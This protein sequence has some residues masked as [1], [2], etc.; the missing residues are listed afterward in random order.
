VPYPYSS[1]IFPRTWITPLRAVGT[2]RGRHERQRPNG[3]RALTPAP[4]KAVGVRS[5]QCPRDRLAGW[6]SNALGPARLVRP[7]QSPCGAQPA[8]V[9]RPQHPGSPGGRTAAPG[10]PPFYA[11]DRPKRRSHGLD[12]VQPG[13]RESTA[14]GA[15]LPT[16]R[17]GETAQR[18]SSRQ[19]VAAPRSARSGVTSWRRK[20]TDKERS[21]S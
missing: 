3:C 15:K 12:G 1:W 9:P 10:G 14:P 18:T 21:P 20:G 16:H 7:A 11:R 13:G 19:G 8:P 17:D 4:D 6:P 5:T 2:L